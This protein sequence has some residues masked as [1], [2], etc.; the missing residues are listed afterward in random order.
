MATKEESNMAEA[1]G[2]TSMEVVEGCR[3]PVKMSGSDEWRK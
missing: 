1:N 3:M 2:E